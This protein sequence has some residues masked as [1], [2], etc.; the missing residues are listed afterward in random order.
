MF[1]TR[2]EWC[3]SLPAS[4]RGPLGSPRKASNDVVHPSSTGGWSLSV[5]GVCMFIGFH[6]VQLLGR[7]ISS[8]LKCFAVTSWDPIHQGLLEKVLN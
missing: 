3:D 4:N 6:L 5:I 8:A 1:A 7:V 2:A